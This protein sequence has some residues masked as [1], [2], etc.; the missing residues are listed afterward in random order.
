MTQR[1]NWIGTA[2][3]L[4][5]L[6]LLFS[7][8]IWRSFQPGAFTGNSAYRLTA[9]AVA[10]GQPV[11]AT[12]VYTYSCTSWRNAGAQAEPTMTPCT[13]EGRALRLDLGRRGDLFI[14]MNGWMADHSGFSGA[15]TLVHELLF[16]AQHG[17]AVPPAFRPVMVRF[18]NPADPATAHVVDP[19]H[20]DR[21]FGSGVRLTALNIDRAAPAIR[22]D[23]IDMALPWLSRQNGAPLS[24]RPGD[25]ALQLH[26]YDFKWPPN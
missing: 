4:L 22:P 20:L 3:V 18:D 13:L 15:D 6:V 16:A 23:E 12:G 19:E 14:V 24:S 11:R 17:R 26:D 5:L 25:P 10:D 2:A 9:V 7:A 8:Y 21:S 1:I